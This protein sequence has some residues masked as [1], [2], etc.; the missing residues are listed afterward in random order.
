[1]THA[2]LISPKFN[3]QNFCRGKFAKVW[4]RQ[5]LALYSSL[6][7]IAQSYFVAGINP[8]TILKA[9]VILICLDILV[10]I[11]S[12]LNKCIQGLQ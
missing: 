1:M 8:T 11:V 6:F 9:V 12:I 7:I 3:P 10:F 5:S 4:H 2:I